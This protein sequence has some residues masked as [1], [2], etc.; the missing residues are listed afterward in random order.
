MTSAFELFS[1]IHDSLV[2]QRSL[3]FRFLASSWSPLCVRLALSSLLRPL[4]T[5]LLQPA[6]L[7]AIKKTVQKKE[8][9]KEKE[10]ETME[11]REDRREKK[12][13]EP[14]ERKFLPRSVVEDFLL[15]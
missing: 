5:S 12:R 6:P 10:K 13:E 15:P 14:K 1:L 7:S 4:D 3:V 2:V 8:K 11:E 9:N